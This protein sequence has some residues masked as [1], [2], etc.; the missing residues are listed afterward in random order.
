MRTQQ[1]SPLSLLGGLLRE[2]R[3]QDCYFCGQASATAVCEPCI[4]ALPRLP[5]ERCPSCAL[6][7]LQGA[8]CGRCMS[9]TPHYDATCAALAYAYPLDA[10]IQAFKYEGRLGLARSFAALIEPAVG[11]EPPDLVVAIP[12]AP[13]RLAERGYNQAHELARLLARRRN[14]K[15]DA[16]AL[17][18][19]KQAPPQ[20]E[21][22]WKERAKNIRGAYTATRRFDGLHVAVVDDVMT[23]GST[24]NELAKVLK[25][26]GA[27]KVTNWVLARTL[28]AAMAPAKA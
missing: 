10:A 27:A 7:T 11:A 9:E 6:P 18:R 14:V 28:P 3:T 22:P 23:T 16:Q 25:K 19:H 12:L 20:A 13:A 1:S 8:L 5:R 26:A 15:L 17:I 2:A 4:A 21:L 24:L